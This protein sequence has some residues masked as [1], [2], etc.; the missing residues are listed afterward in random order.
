MRTKFRTS[1]RATLAGLVLAAAGAQAQTYPERTIKLVI[2]WPAGGLVDIAGRTLAEKLQA[3]LGQSMIIE[4]KPG[5]GGMIGAESV[6][7]AAP[8]GYTLLLTSSALNINLALGRK[9][10]APVDKA[11]VP[12]RVVSWAPSILVVHPDAK[13]RSVKAL[14][15]LAKSRPAGL[16]YASAGIGSPAHFAAEMLRSMTSIPLVHVPYKGAPA[17]MTD[18]VAGRVDFHFANAAVAAPQIRAGKVTALAITSAK[19]SPAFPDLP[20]MAES[21][22]PD[23]KADQW[24]GYFAPAGTPPAI[25]D[26]LSAALGRAIADPGVQAALGKR[27]MSVDAESSP[28]SFAALM[29]SDLA[30]LQDVV[31]KANIK[32]D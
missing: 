14:V 26:R 12:I 32:V 25:V 30:R 17:A 3:E 13:L 24:L 9:L 16:T 8:D 21:G 29:K 4:N 28:A 6:V 5:A 27:L 22:Y 19:R 10:S 23:M 18:Q 20:T 7:K 31:R 11:F 1:V 15:D 2:P